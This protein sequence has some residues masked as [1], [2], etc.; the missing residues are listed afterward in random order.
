[1]ADELP[2]IGA[3]RTEAEKGTNVGT[4]DAAVRTED[5]KEISE[6]ITATAALAFAG[7]ATGIGKSYI[8]ATAG[9]AFDSSSADL[10]GFVMTASTSMAFDV[11]SA[12]LIKKIPVRDCTV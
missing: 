7:S 4:Y 3:L 5:E 2:K 1:M 6:N 12:D 9:M 10:F 11:S 8:T